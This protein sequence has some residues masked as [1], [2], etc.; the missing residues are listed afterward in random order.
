[1]SRL[2]LAEQRL[3]GALEK[4]ESREISRVRVHPSQAAAVTGFL[5]ATAGGDAVEVVADGRCD[6]GGV[7]FETPRGNLD[8]SVETQL[9]EIERG[10]AD[11]LR[12]R[13]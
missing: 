13:P 12:R 11:T 6:P 7:V 5:R 8:A 2:D 1:M 10:L 3:A 4:L 9:Q